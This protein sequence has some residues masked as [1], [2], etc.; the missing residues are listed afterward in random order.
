MKCVGASRIDYD[1]FTIIA[2]FRSKS[3]PLR[4]R[5]ISSCAAERH[6]ATRHCAASVTA[7]VTNDAGKIHAAIAALDEALIDR[8]C[9]GAEWRGGAGRARGGLGKFQILEHHGRGEP[10]FV[11]AVRWRGRH[12]PRYRTI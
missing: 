1:R 4:R 10:R 6:M 8:S 2:A 5:A 7:Q 11:V 9:A 12:Q 3:R